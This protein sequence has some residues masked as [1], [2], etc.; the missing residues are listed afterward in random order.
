MSEETITKEWEDGIYRWI[1][2]GYLVDIPLR[3][4]TNTERIKHLEDRYKFYI[5]SMGRWERM[6]EKIAKRDY[7]EWTEED[8]KDLC[9]RRDTAQLLKQALED[10]K[11]HANGMKI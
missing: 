10:L 3:L 4:K 1:I 2:N 8:E 6:K 9:D 5:E 7:D 11:S